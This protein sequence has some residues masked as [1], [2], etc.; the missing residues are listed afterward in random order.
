MGAKT[1]HGKVG[2]SQACRDRVRYPDLLGV[3][4]AV[5]DV[6]FIFL[7]GLNE[8]SLEALG[9]MVG[10]KSKAGFFVVYESNKGGGVGGDCR[11]SRVEFPFIKISMG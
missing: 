10:V 7:M 6:K 11:D 8:V 9:P 2:C 3:S 1:H 4:G 5:E